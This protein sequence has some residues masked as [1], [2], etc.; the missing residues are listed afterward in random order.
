MLAMFSQLRKHGR[1]IPGDDGYQLMYRPGPEE[2]K[3]RDLFL[4]PDSRPYSR[5]PICW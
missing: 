3:I 1:V 5:V 4:H 2:E